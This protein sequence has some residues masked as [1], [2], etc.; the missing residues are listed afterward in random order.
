MRTVMPN[1]LAVGE[2]AK[3]MNS[4]HRKLR[5]SNSCCSLDCLFVYRPDAPDKCKIFT[6]YEVKL[7]HLSGKVRSVL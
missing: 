1:S 3:A 7:D 4:S 2:G 6:V 5:S